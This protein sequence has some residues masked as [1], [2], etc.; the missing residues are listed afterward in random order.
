MGEHYYVYAITAPDT[1]LPQSVSVF[2][3]PLLMVSYRDL[4]AIVSRIGTPET[5][6]M[7]P[8]ATAENLLRHERVVEMARSHGRALPV[9][10]GTVLPSREAVAQA[11]ATQ[12][13]T[14]LDDLRRIGD[15]NE[16]EIAA[17]WG[18]AT[19]KPPSAQRNPEVGG[20]PEP[21]TAPVGRRAGLA[22]LLSRQA[23]YR[24]A[25]S[26]RERAQT[27]A[28]DL[29]ARLRPL[30]L[31]CRRSLCPTERLALRDRYLVEN[32][33]TG[34][35]KQAFDEVRLRHQEVRFLLSGPWPPYSFVTPPARHDTPTMQEGER[36]SS[37]S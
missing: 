18:L 31:E 9:R 14:L 12:H 23:E 37:H 36:I 10:F 13:A 34:A 24:Q 2:G 27:L 7:A 3:G 19:E 35:F 11:L 20:Q 28:R 33:R 30:A 29:D 26:A 15:K 16:I 8:S 25:E 22:Y 1:Q 17:L 32:E 21:D 5:D 4:G 6:G